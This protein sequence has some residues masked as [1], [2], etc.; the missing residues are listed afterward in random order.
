MFRR[1]KGGV[2]DCTT[3]ETEEPVLGTSWGQFC[4][5]HIKFQLCS[6]PPRGDVKREVECVSSEKRCGC[7]QHTGKFKPMGVNSIRDDKLQRKR[8]ANPVEDP[9]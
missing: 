2:D 8:E 1:T 9:K 7:H 5:G 6:R 4:L 3:N